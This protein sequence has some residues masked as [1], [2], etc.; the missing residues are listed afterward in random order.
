MNKSRREIAALVGRID[1][2]IE[3]KVEDLRSDD[4]HFDGAFNQIFDTPF[5]RNH[6]TLLKIGE[7]ENGR[8]TWVPAPLK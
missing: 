6:V 7:P 1:L 8:L 5:T 2:V 3:A 4:L